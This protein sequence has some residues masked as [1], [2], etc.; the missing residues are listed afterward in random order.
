MKPGPCVPAFLFQLL[1]IIVFPVRQNDTKFVP[2]DYNPEN[3]AT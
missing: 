1:E 3:Y 2:L